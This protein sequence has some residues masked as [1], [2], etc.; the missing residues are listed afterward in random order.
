[1]EVRDSTELYYVIRQFRTRV[2]NEEEL[3]KEQRLQLLS[4]VEY[5]YALHEYL[6]EDGISAIS[7][8]VPT[9]KEAE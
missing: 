8:L 7:T 1:M 6:V 9:L 4:I 2:F 3:S 5:S